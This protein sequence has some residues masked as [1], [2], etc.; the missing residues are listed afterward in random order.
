MRVRVP[1]PTPLEG[2]SVIPG[3]MSEIVAFATDW[4]NPTCDACREHNARAGGA[5]INRCHDLDPEWRCF[6]R[7]WLTSF[8]NGYKGHRMTRSMSIMDAR[9]YD[10]AEGWE[11]NPDT[12]ILHKLIEGVDPHP[13]RKRY[14]KAM[15]QFR[16]GEGECGCRS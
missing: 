7:T 8:E 11:P 12:G 5:W 6:D 1:S 16:Y 10:W 14:I 13:E 4:A 3:T 9:T 15:L 2:H